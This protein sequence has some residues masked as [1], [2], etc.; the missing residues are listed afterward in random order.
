M[1]RATF[2]LLIA[3]T[4][5]ANEACAQSTAPG[6]DPATAPA[7]A[8]PPGPGAGAAPAET[9]AKGKQLEG[10]TVTGRRLLAKPCSPRDQ[11]CVSMVVAELKARY[12]QE[13][14]HWCALVEERAAAANMMGDSLEPD[15]LYN[16]FHVSGHAAPPEVTKTACSLGKK[17]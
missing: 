13:L 17:P 12:P 10:V 15:Q 5:F 14:Q 6:K 16:P 9:A 4:L 1:L 8:A 2:G 3:A 11:A 7:L